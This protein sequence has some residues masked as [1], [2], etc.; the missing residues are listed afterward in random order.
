MNFCKFA[1]FGAVTITLSAC[2]GTDPV[3]QFE[4][5][6][7]FADSAADT[8]VE[9]AINGG[10]SGAMTG[11]G[12][13]SGAVMRRDLMIEL[14]S[15]LNTATVTLG[16]ARFVLTADLPNP[17]V[18]FGTEYVDG[19][20][21]QFAMGPTPFNDEEYVYLV[22]LYDGLTHL[23]SGFAGA[24]TRIENLPE[25]LVNYT[26]Y[27]RYFVAET[28]ADTESFPATT[29]DFDLDVD[30]G[31]GGVSGNLTDLDSQVSTVAGAVTGNGFAA[32]VSVTDTDLSGTIQMDGT[33]FGPGAEEVGGIFSGDIG[34]TRGA[35]EVFGRFSGDELPI[36][37]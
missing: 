22:Y 6:P 7:Q 27:F 35:R 9:K 2:G 20:G 14:S 24:E 21:L 37:P 3:V 13:T 32:D 29:G 16:G 34:T 19:S 10:V 17:G 5:V 30:F 23:Y 4:H 11:Q 28:P 1:P 31:T 18:P 26:G 12:G 8:F 25:E 15:D 36:P 33:F